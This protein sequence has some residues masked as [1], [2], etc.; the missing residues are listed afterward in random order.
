MKIQ[1]NHESMIWTPMAMSASISCFYC[2][3]V[4]VLVYLKIG[5]ND[6]IFRWRIKMLSPNYANLCSDSIS[7]EEDWK[8]QKNRICMSHG[9]SNVIN[10]YCD[11]S[12]N[13]HTTDLLFTIIH[14]N[15]INDWE[16]Y[17][18][19]L[20][21]EIDDNVIFSP[22]NYEFVRVIPTRIT[23]YFRLTD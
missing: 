10:I 23:N 9:N 6:C 20:E 11:L 8:K 3:T 14:M 15:D 1:S 18:F 17:L 5:V 21:Y 7:Q 2:E 19:N 4:Y 22:L 12:E 13:N 16:R